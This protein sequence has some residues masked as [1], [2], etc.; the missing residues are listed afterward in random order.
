VFAATQGATAYYASAF[1]VDGSSVTPL[2]SGGSAPSAGTASS[3]DI[4]V[5]TIIKT[6]ATP[7][8]EVFASV[9]AFA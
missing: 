4:Y 8:Y 7:T 3:V 5:F 6:A 2:W 9:T 1:Q